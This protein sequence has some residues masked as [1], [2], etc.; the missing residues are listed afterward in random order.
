MNETG[1]NRISAHSSDGQ[2]SAGV[3]EACALPAV[4]PTISPLR[5]RNPPRTRPWP[6]GTETPV[7]SIFPR[8]PGKRRRHAPRCPK[9]ALRELADIIGRVHSG[10]LESPTRAAPSAYERYG[11]CVARSV[12]PVAGRGSGGPSSGRRPPCAA[13]SLSEASS[14]A[15]LARLVLA[16]SA[17]LAQQTPVQRAPHPAG[18]GG[19]GLLVANRPRLSMTGP[20]RQR[21]DTSP[22]RRL[23]EETAW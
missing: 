6:R 10:Q 8:K 3:E 15:A 4:R 7:P 23:T 9:R 19:C 16:A 14:A 17:S 21:L 1:R 20:D 2:A 11:D 5:R 13:T 22:A 18:T 12:T